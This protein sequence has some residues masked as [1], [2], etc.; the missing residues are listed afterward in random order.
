MS[1]VIYLVSCV[2]K[3]K[4]YTLPAKD[5]YDS[6][7]FLKARAYVESRADTWFI[8]SAEYGLL[9][10]EKPI[11]PYEKTLNKMRVNERKT[12]ADMVLKDLSNILQPTDTV[13]ILAGL[14]YREFL[15]EGLIKL[16][17]KIEI[18]LEGLRIG[19]QLQW[20]RIHGRA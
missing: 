20:F 8:L 18:P 16:C 1:R 7:W 17:A 15:M 3:K 9:S 19:V 5:L 11:A 13:V 2:S 6:P 4:P 14:R 10:P 12:W